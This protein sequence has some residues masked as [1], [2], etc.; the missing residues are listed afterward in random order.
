MQGFLIREMLRSPSWE[1]DPT[2]GPRMGFPKIGGTTGGPN[3]DYIILV[4]I[5]VS[6]PLSRETTVYLQQNTM[7]SQICE[8]SF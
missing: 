1:Q 2:Q 4:S 8:T 5:L 6:P 3:E 7:D